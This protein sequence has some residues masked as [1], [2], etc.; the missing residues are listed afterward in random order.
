[1]KLII[2]GKANTSFVTY[3]LD[4]GLHNKWDNGN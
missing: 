3:T 4:N 1:M 2:M